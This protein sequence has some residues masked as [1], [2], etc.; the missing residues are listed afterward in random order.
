MLLNVVATSLFYSILP[1]N[2]E[3]LFGREIVCYTTIM[4]QA[5]SEEKYCMMNHK[6]TTWYTRENGTVL[7]PFSKAIIKNKVLIGR[8]S[9]HDEVSSDQQS[10]QRLSTVS[11]LSNRVNTAELER[12]QRNLDER[13]GFDR[14]QTQKTVPDEILQKRTQERRANENDRDIEYRQLRTLLIKRYRQHKERLFLPLVVVFLIMSIILT[15]ALLFP[16]KLPNPLPNCET[17]AGPNINWNNCSKSKL[18]LHHQDFNGAQL[19]N[20]KLPGSNLWNSSFIA[21]D[22]AYAD[23]RFTN[24]SYGQLQDSILIGANLQKADLSYA[25][26]TNADLSF[27]D[28][29]AANIGGSKLDNAIFDSAIWPDGS[30]CASGSIGQCIVVTP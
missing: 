18:D 19:R 1:R 13:D 14:R 9:D 15:L 8:L 23:L 5:R 30:T 2:C 12:A 20:S 4:Y 16:T 21:A 11:E 22:L 6:I 24:L 17:A 28:L 10:W 27:A 7:G 3:Y 29:T 26:L 25:D